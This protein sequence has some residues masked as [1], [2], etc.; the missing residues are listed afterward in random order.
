MK[1]LEVCQIC[2]EPVIKLNH[3][4]HKHGFTLAEYCTQQF[5]RRD[6][7]TKEPIVFKTV[8]QYFSSDFLIIGLFGAQYSQ[9]EPIL[10]IFSAVLLLFFIN[11]PLATVV[12]ERR[13]PDQRRNLLAIQRPQFRQLRQK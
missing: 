11:A 13:Q 12:R 7:L 6:I 3:F 4:F 1:E 2:N 5:N 10:R 8:D 9:A